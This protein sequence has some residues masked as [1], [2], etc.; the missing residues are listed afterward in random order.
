M[1]RTVTLSWPTAEAPNTEWVGAIARDEQVS[2][3]FTTPAAFAPQRAGYVSLCEFNGPPCPREGALSLSPT[4]YSEGINGK[5]VFDGDTDVEISFQFSQPT[6][7]HAQPALVLLPATT[8]YFNVQ[9]VIDQQQEGVTSFGVRVA[10][11]A[12]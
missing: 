2:F 12:H 9:N 11:Q 1:S 8:Y 4:D 3:T 7:K 5:G 10:L 6:G